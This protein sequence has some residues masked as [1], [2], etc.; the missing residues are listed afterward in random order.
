M[1]LE[2]SL[3]VCEEFV[4]LGQN[5]EENLFIAEEF[6]SPFFSSGTG[7]MGIEGLKRIEEEDEENLGRGTRNEEDCI[8]DSA[9]IWVWGDNTCDNTRDTNKIYNIYYTQLT[10]TLSAGTVCLLI[11]FNCFSSS[12][13]FP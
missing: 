7:Y 2:I 10:L 6:L 8:E 4:L 13:V 5:I 9:N 11:L 3:E 1:E 12:T